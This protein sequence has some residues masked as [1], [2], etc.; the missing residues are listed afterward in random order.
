MMKTLSC[1]GQI[2]D[3][4]QTKTNENMKDKLKDLMKR[5]RPKET[6]NNDIS[7]WVNLRYYAPFKIDETKL[8]MI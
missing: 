3:N 2:V 6:Q 5:F 8:Q 4:L 7:K 1:N